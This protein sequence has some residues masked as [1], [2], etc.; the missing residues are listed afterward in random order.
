MRFFLPSIVISF[1]TF[2]AMLLP[3][4]AQAHEVYI[5]SQEQIQSA[6]LAPPLDVLSIIHDETGRFFS[7]M[8][9]VIFLLIFVFLISISRKLEKR[10][11]PWLLS[12]KKYAP[13]I[14]RI[15]L[16]LSIINMAYHK[17]ILGPELPFAS[18]LSSNY[19]TAFTIFLYIMGT[20]VLLGLWT[21]VAT[22]LLF[23]MYVLLTF[24]YGLYMFTYTN[25]FGA[26]ILAFALGPQTFSIDRLLPSHLTGY[27]R[28]IPEWL[29]RHAFLI[30]RVSFGLS[31]MYA[32]F[33][34]K[35]LHAD[36]AMDVVSTF[37]LTDFFH[38]SHNF[39]VLGAFILEMLLGL[40]FVLGIELR[41]SAIFLFIFALLSLLY[42]KEDMWPHLILAGSAIAIF[43]RGYGPDTLESQIL[44][45]FKRFEEP[46]L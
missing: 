36:L 13:F 22:L 3:V 9:L 32:S 46:I 43:F 11:D 29:E 27:F 4:P 1:M 42:F 45:R 38:F 24:K 8:F 28:N 34:A 35:F 39:L 15:T 6:L 21:R 44:R 12:I 16:G 7:W 14:V 30:L 17:S 10:F 18:L 23:V 5:L 2:G 19:I 26:I 33:Y 41:F 20:L 31:L 37:N 25:Y 40:L